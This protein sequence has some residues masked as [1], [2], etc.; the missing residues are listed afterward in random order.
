LLKS[1]HFKNY[2]DLNT[3]QGSTIRHSK[4]IAID[5]QIPFPSK[6]NHQEPEE[7]ENLVSLIIQNLIDKEEQIKLKNKIIDEKIE[8][9]LRENQIS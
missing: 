3:A 6:N 9:E 8:K 7:I 2:I 5:Y 4:Q 1:Q